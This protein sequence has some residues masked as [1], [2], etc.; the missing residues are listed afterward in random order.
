MAYCLPSDSSAC[1]M[2]HTEFE[3]ISPPNAFCV[4]LVKHLFAEEEGTVAVE[5]D[6]SSAQRQLKGVMTDCN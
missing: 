5:G 4:K 6:D 1:A 3:I 2:S